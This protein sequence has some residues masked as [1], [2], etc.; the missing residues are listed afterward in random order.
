MS[1]AEALLVLGLLANIA[2]IIDVSCK[3]LER[4]QDVKNGKRDL[5]KAFQD[6]QDT[7][8][9]LRDALDK[10]KSQIEGGT[11]SERSCKSVGSILSD[12]S[13]KMNELELIFR[14][15]KPKE[16]ATWFER[17]WK[18]VLTLRQDRK[19]EELAKHIWRLVSLLTYHH[20]VS[21]PIESRNQL[22]DLSANLSIAQKQ[23]TRYFSVPKYR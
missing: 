21:P 11:L 4:I 20:V 3:A 23:P 22:L 5:P 8:P 10:T 19:V 13:A 14:E 18:A 15:C 2:G 12:C 17:E 9:L 16:N 1:G 7:L 6:I